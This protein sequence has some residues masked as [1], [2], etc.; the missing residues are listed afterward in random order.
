METLRSSITTDGQRVFLFFDE[1]RGLYRLATRWSWLASFDSVW[2]GCDA[3]EALEMMEGDLRQAAR[4]IKR[5][6]SRVPRHRFGSKRNSMGRTNYLIDSVI[7]RLSGL[8]QVICG[9]K[10]AITKWVPV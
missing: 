9:S 3:F 4:A 10:G 1:T 6:I 2:D 7:K 5:E 8:R